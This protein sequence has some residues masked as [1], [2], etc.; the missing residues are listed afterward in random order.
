MKKFSE[1]NLDQSNIPDLPSAGRARR[2]PG[3]SRGPRPQ[4]REFDIRHVLKAA[5]LDQ[6]RTAARAERRARKYA[7]LRHRA[8]GD[9]G[10]VMWLMSEAGT[11]EEVR[12]E[13]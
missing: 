5:F 9:V 4:Q 1:E 12:N 7:S 3:T 11:L 10:R 6:P 2:G 13:R 8:R